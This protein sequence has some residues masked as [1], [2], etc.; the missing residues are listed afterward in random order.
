MATSSLLYY[1]AA[2][3]DTDMAGE[4]HHLHDPQKT[5]RQGDLL[6]PSWL[7]R[8]STSNTEHPLD[9]IKIYYSVF[10]HTMHRVSSQNNC[11]GAAI[12]ASERYRCISVSGVLANMVPPLI[13]RINML[14]L[15]KIEFIVYQ[16]PTRITYKILHVNCIPHHHQNS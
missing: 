12:I 4:E 13:P 16:P 5:K 9:D 14:R 1:Y 11:N 8:K 6:P 10:V 2:A 3:C 7:A 15:Q